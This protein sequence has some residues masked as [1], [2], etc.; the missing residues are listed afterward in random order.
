MLLKD[1]MI[2]L[3]NHLRPAPYAYGLLSLRLLGK[4]GGKNRQF[5]SCM[6]DS[7][8]E[9][10]WDVPAFEIKC[11]WKRSK[12][13]VLENTQDDKMDAD[14]DK[15]N[16]GKEEELDRFTLPLDDVIV[17]AANV[18]KRVACAPKLIISKKDEDSNKANEQENKESSK[19]NFPRTCDAVIKAKMELTDL[20]KHSIQIMEDTKQQQSDAALT[21]LRGALA[22]IINVPT[23]TSIPYTMERQKQPQYQDINEVK[24]T[25][26]DAYNAKSKNHQEYIY[27]Q[28]CQGLV[29]A[30]L[31]NE[32]ASTLIHGL[33][34][35]SLFLACC[36]VSC[37][38]RVDAAGN[39]VD[40][41]YFSDNNGNSTGMRDFHLNLG[42][43]NISIQ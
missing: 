42:K 8:L 35:H 3:C 13:A 15:T 38:F 17:S 20:P 11:S 24:D 21:I 28:I 4:L 23:D 1:I 32:E 39:V 16:E 25:I 43:D 36:H 37:I 41:Q 33:A 40:D 19:D 5:L 12:D 6:M 18:L 27:R 30:S 29:Y 7:S 22:S 31:Q 26:M 14:D 9:D 2:S 10:G 34:S